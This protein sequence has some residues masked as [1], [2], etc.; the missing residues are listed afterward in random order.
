MLKHKI[1]LKVI[2]TATLLIVMHPWNL[3]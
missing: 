2:F 3:L 1:K